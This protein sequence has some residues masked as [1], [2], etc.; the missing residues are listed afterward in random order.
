[1]PPALVVILVAGTGLSVGSFL[2]VCIH[3]LPRHLSIVTPRSACPAC[4][5]PIAWHD[6]LPVL[7]YLLLG[8]RCRRCRAPISLLYPL[9]EAATA[10]LFLLILHA[11][12]ATPLFMLEAYLAAAL[13]AL[14]LIDARHQILPN[15]ITLPGIAV[16]LLT[17]PLRAGLDE[18][19]SASG[20]RSLRDA[21]FAASCGFAIPWCI[22]ALYRLWQAGRGV[23][24][25]ER[26]DGIGRGDFKL[27]AM[28]GAFLGLELL[29]FCLFVGAISGAVFGV[30][31]MRY[32][33]YGWKS[34]LPY[35]VFLGAAAILALFAG[36]ASVRLY[37]RLVGIAT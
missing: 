30:L 17:S 18:T 20:L 12:G 23:P 27:L 11:R 14:I 34:K 35:G 1:M 36:E 26:E 16:G 37:L 32:A 8:G 29:L 33:G 4:A 2:N 6:N 3:R 10:I 5:A 25:A 28:I 13:V 7:S 24:A 15:A 21:L 9:V 22:N 31:M 19:A